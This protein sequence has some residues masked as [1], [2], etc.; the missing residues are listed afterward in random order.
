MISRPWRDRLTFLA[1]SLFVAW[2]A[3]AIL[4]TPAPSGSPAVEGLKALFRPY[5]TFFRLESSWS[6]FANVFRHTQFRYVIEDADGKQHTFIPM[7][8]FK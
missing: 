5:T 6:F 2:H 7:D 4:V 8:E 3:T 1:M